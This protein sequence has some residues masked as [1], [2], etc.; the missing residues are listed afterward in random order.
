[1]LH[2]GLYEQV[3]N[4]KLDSELAGI[5][6]TRKAVAPIDKAATSQVLAQYISEVV[7]NGLDKMLDEGG[8]IAAANCLY[9]NS[10]PTALRAEP[11]PTPILAQP[12]T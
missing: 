8:D 5:A 6:E 11:R 1:M 9:G 2:P 12:A 3:I 7:Q 10:R 4:R